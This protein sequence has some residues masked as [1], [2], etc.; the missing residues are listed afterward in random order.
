MRTCAWVGEVIV[1][2]LCH[3]V[4]QSLGSIAQFALVCKPFF[5][6]T[7]SPTLWRTA[8]ESMFSNSSEAFMQPISDLVFSTYQGQWLRMIKEKPRIRY[9]GVYIATCQYVR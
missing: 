9:D 3:L 4:L 1:H 6:L 7:R 5:L 8:C 2:I